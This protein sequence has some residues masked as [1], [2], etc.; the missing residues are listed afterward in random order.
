MMVLLDAIIFA[1]HAHRPRTRAASE[2]WKV[3]V[4]RERAGGVLEREG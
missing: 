4:L 2:S 1:P 3:I